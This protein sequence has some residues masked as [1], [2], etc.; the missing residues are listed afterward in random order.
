VEPRATLTVKLATA[1]VLGKIKVM[2]GSRDSFPY[3]VETSSDGVQWKTIAT[4]PATSNGTDEFTSPSV[5]AKF[6]RLVFEG[7]GTAKPPS[8]AELIVFSTS[9]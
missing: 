2:R 9:H 7:V 8:I 5:E 4:A 6:L 3:T 1:A